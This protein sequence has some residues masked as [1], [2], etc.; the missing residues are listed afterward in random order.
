MTV[1]PDR[2][3]SLGGPVDAL[4]NR[5]GTYRESAR[6]R[7]TGREPFPQP[8][9]A[10]ADGE[11]QYASPETEL[12]GRAETPQQALDLAGEVDRREDEGEGEREGEPQRDTDRRAVVVGCVD[13]GDADREERDVPQP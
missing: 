8:T 11:P 10:G 2:A 12:E 7:T 5:L 13:G 4:S 1:A 6:R 9:G 3:A